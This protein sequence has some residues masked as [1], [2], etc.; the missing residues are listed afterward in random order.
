MWRI[1]NKKASSFFF[2][3]RSCVHPLP[4]AGEPMP[5]CWL[6]AGLAVPAAPGGWHGGDVGESRG[7][8][9]KAVSYTG[10]DWID[11]R[12]CLVTELWGWVDWG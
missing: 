10:R 5:Q 6:S 11:L 7:R 9:R 4:E 1:I 2:L 8:R 3:T 12:L